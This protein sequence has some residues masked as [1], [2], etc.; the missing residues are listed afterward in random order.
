MI[1]FYNVI[2]IV[3]TEIVDNLLILDN[4][5]YTLYSKWAIGL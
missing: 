1:R 2:H 5:N 4:N 3:H